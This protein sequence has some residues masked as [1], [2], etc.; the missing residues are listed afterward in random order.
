MSVVALVEP[1]SP[2]ALAT[3]IR[4]FLRDQASGREAGRRARQ[5]VAERFTIR[6]MVERTQALYERLL[7][8]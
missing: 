8:A 1:G 5:Q 4:K 6:G 3:G 7:A 2:E